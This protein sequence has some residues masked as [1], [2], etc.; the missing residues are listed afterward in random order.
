LHRIGRARAHAVHR[1][2]IGRRSS[3]T[4]SIGSAVFAMISRR[5]GACCAA[6]RKDIVSRSV[7]VIGELHVAQKRAT[8]LRLR[9]YAA[10][11]AANAT[12]LGWLLD[13]AWVRPD[14]A[15]VD[16]G[17]AEAGRDRLLRVIAPLAAQA[18]LPSLLIGVSDDEVHRF[19]QVMASLP[20][21]VEL[22][23]VVEAITRPT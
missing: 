3:L 1:R 5:Y 11:I 18:G 12:D 8:D 6:R 17:R 2:T 21:D 22:E 4:V 14:V 19:E 15:V 9:G 16:L 13:Q 23:R 7:L 20:S 10:W